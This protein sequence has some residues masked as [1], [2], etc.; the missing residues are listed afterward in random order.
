M[1]AK[2]LAWKYPVRDVRN[3]EWVELTGA[4]FYQIV[5]EENKKPEKTRFFMI[6]DDGIDQGMEPYVLETTKEKFKEWNKE[7]CAKNRRR[8]IQNKYKRILVSMDMNINEDSELT[9]YDVIAD[10]D[11][12]VAE[13][14]ELA[15]LIEELRTA[16]SFLSEEEKHILD[17][18]YFDNE[19]ELSERA[20]AE[21]NGMSKSSLN[22]EKQK[23]LK[24]L[25]ESLGQK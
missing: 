23:I 10:E 17:L 9:Y 4:E 22:R 18:L 5:K 15:M 25:R 6:V 1:T 8:R 20:I 12:S 3:P 11:V 7:Y 16:I 21:E 2:Y 13:R 19:D 24:K 14:V